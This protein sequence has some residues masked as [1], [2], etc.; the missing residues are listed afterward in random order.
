MDA[1]KNFSFPLEKDK[2]YYSCILPGYF[3]ATVDLVCVQFHVNKSLCGDLYGEAYFST[4]SSRA[5]YNHNELEVRCIDGSFSTDGKFLIKPCPV[6]YYCKPR[7][8]NSVY[9]SYLL[10]KYNMNLTSFSRYSSIPI[11]TVKG[12]SCGRSQPSD[13]IIRLIENFLINFSKK[14]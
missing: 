9:F 14:S 13:W 2:I 11:D 7:Y 1:L 3:R 6:S 5:F 10:H 4:I 8:S 12:W